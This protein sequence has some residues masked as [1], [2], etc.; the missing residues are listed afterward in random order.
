MEPRP[1]H[2]R[3]DPG[4]PASIAFDP[5]VVPEYLR[6][7]A[8]RFPDGTA[9]KFMNAH[10]TW[11]ELD[12]A[13]SRF[14]GVLADSGIP[15]GARVAIQLPNL[16]QT[17]IAF[18]GT[19]RAGCVTVMTNPLAMPPE[20]ARQWR[21]AGCEA[22]V[23]ADFLWGKVAPLRD[24]LPVREWLIASIPE[25]LRFPLRQLAPL[26]L[27]RARPPL[28]GDVPRA[29]HVRR[30]REVVGATAPVLPP[31][32]T[33][34]ELAALQYTGGTTGVS[35]G[36][37]L[38]HGNFSVQA[39]QFIAWMPELVPGNEVFLSALPFFHVFGLTVGLILPVALG[40]T[41][42][43][44]ANP[45]DIGRLIAAVKQQ[46]VSVFPIVPALV[47]AISTDD[48]AR[49]FETRHLKLC[50]S[51]SAPLPEATLTQFEKATGGRIVEGYGL[52]EAS[53]VT[54]VNPTR[55]LRKVNSIGM[56]LPETDCRLVSMD[57]GE[58]P[59]PP[60][61]EGELLIRGPQ[62][63]RGYW[64][65]PDETA[66]AIRD[67]WLHTGDLASVDEDGYFRIVGRKKDMIVVGGYKV[68]PDEVDRTLVEHDDVLEAATIGVPDDRRGEIVKSFVVVRPGA[69][70][71]ADALKG[72]CR[73][74]LA[75]YKIPREI[76][77][78]EALPKSSALKVLR[79]ELLAEELR[80]RPQS[81]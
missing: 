59:V 26:K 17:V 60:G 22:A 49:H 72:F 54:H 42:I 75:A 44:E 7:S 79:R 6:R 18:L 70:F 41:M 73:E 56:P 3:Y 19:L 67:G 48:R 16:P 25:Y 15:R 81:G 34:D 43:V 50:V 2:A 4:V 10:M 14:A 28:L 78:R 45:R 80:R 36:A 35:K 38:T 51:G 55:G 53:P 23:V 64:N 24:E 61:S 58:S 5:I 12:D 68:Y 27:K 76:E 46:K 1:W 69:V 65:R 74:R 30:F 13:A 40:A 20:I 21:D 33:L 32:P 37:M 62:V 31:A 63:M 71:N 66:G 52:T 57:D 8:E 11:R 47:H 9:I 39:Q 77:S 29:P